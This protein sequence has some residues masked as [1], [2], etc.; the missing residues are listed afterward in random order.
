MP[1][2]NRANKPQSSGPER[3]GV[4]AYDDFKRLLPRISVAHHVKERIRLKIDI[5]LDEIRKTDLQ[6]AKDFQG[7]LDRL[8]GIREVRVN[9]LAKSSTIVY[10]ETVI[11]FDAWADFLAQKQTAPAM[12]LAQI[13]EEGYREVFDV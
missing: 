6:P 11:P 12:K 3:A 1:S 8:P 5:S 13:L 2:Q 10:D 7:V 9:V 4:P